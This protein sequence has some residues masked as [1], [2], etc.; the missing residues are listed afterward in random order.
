MMMET[1]KQLIPNVTVP[2]TNWLKDL[3][4]DIVPSIS[5]KDT[6]YKSKKLMGWRHFK[7]KNLKKIVKSNFVLYFI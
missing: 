5:Y 7:I 2:I 4:K 1:Y 6:D 3:K